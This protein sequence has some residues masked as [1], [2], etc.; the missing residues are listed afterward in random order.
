MSRM[1]TSSHDTRRKFVAAYPDATS[2]HIAA[3]IAVIAG[4]PISS[5]SMPTMG[6]EHTYPRC[7]VTE[8]RETKVGE[9]APAATAARCSD[10]GSDGS[11]RADESW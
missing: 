10:H 6:A 3:A 2:G 7:A 4:N 9:L 11:T 8:T 1:R 5:T